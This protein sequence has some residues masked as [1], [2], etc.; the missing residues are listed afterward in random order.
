[1]GIFEK[2]GMEK[3][4][5][6][7]YLICNGGDL[8]WLKLICPDKHEQGSSSKGYFSTGLESVRKDVECVF[9]IVKKR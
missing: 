3:T 6:R 4:D 9:G 8:C 7:I 2:D 5:T 1:M